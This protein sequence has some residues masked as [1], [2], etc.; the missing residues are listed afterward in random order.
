MSFN[1]YEND[2]RYQMDTSSLR[3]QPRSPADLLAER[4]AKKKQQDMAMWGNVAQVGLPI[5]GMAIGGALGAMGGP[6][7][8]AAGAATGGGLGQ[9]A[10]QAVGQ[11]FANAGEQALDPI[12]E[13]EMK[14]Q[15]QEMR[16]QAMMQA[17]MQMPRR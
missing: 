4:A 1:R 7:G 10:G 12:R 13:Q 11:G 8:V 17:I 14:R 16:R 9:T 6:G 2:P 15:E 5:A 3:R